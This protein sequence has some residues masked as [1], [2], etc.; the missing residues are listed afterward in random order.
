MN[1][2]P[3]EPPWGYLV[4]VACFVFLALLGFIFSLAG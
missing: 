3:S 1:V 2:A 4:V